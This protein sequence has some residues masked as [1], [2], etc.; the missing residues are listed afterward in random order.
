MARSAFRVAAQELEVPGRCYADECAYPDFVFADDAAVGARVL[1]EPKDG[2]G[3]H[4]HEGTVIR[5]VSPELIPDQRIQVPYGWDFSALKAAIKDA[6]LAT[7]YEGHPKITLVDRSSKIRICADN[8]LSWAV[9][10][11]W[12]KLI[13]WA[14]LVYPLVWLFKRFNKEGGGKWEVCGGA[15]PLQIRYDV[16]I[17]P[18]GQQSVAVAQLMG[19]REGEWFAQWEGTIQRAVCSRLRTSAP[20]ELPLEAP[21]ARPLM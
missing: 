19:S 11:P 16:P 10:N 14:T 1:C 4:I 6:I 15:Y 2:Q 8:G 17:P 3:V 20:L 18:P 12:P 9:T 5:S 21:L 13:M 7:G